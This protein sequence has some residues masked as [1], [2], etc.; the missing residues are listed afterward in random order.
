MVLKK[1]KVLEVGRIVLDQHQLERLQCIVSVEKNDLANLLLECAQLTEGIQQLCLLKKIGCMLRKLGG[2]DVHHSQSSTC[3]EILVRIYW[4]LE[5]R[6]PLKRATASALNGI[7]ENLKEEVVSCLISCLKKEMLIVDKSHIRK[8]IDSIA[9]CM[10]NFSLGEM[11]TQY[12]YLEVLQFLHMTLVDFKLQN[13]NLGGQHILQNKLMHD[14]L[15]ALKATMVLVQKVQEKIHDVLCRNTESSL[16]E[17]MCGLLTCV[18]EILLDGDFLQTV[19]STAG[20]AAL[21]F[22]KTIADC[23][24]LLPKLVHDL[25]FNSNQRA[26]DVPEWLIQSCG[27]LYST[28]PP[29]DVVLFLSQGSLAMLDW[30]GG[31]MRNSG[32]HLLLDILTVLLSLN[33]RLKESSMAMTVSRNLSLWTT[34]ALDAL[35]VDTCSQYLKN[36]LNGNSEA[37][38][39][40]LEYI[41]THWEHPLDGVR[42]QTKTIFKNI[43]KIHQK[44]IDDTCVLTDPFFLNITHNLMSLEW[45]VKGKYVLLGCLVE[46]F[47][48]EHI[49]TVDESIPKQ[50]LGINLEQS[51]ATYA[52]DLLEKMFVS[53]KNQLISSSESGYW[54]KRWHDIWVSPFL[55]KLCEEKPS[56]TTYIIECYLPKLLKCNPDSLTF[57]I[58]ELQSS[59]KASNVGPFNNRGALGALMTCLRAARA[60]GLLST[61]EE[62]AWDE[63]IPISLI[64]QALVHK[65]EQVCLDALGLICETHCSTEALSQQEIALIKYFLPYNMNSQSPAMRQQIVWLMK[66]LFSRLRDSSQVLYKQTQPTKQKNALCE[67]SPKSQQAEIQLQQYKD[68]MVWICDTL[69]QALFPGASFP[70]KFIALNLLGIIAEVFENLE[71]QTYRVMQMT[72]VLQ[73]ANVDALL[74]CL[75]STFE[76]LKLLAYD[77]LKKLPPTVLGLQDSE[78]LQTLLQTALDLSTSTK[79]YD[80]ITASYLLSLL[81]QQEGLMP[82]LSACPLK[83]QTGH[84]ID[85]LGKVCGKQSTDKEVLETNVLEVIK[86]LLNCLSDEI[87]QA[88]RSLV[89]TAASNPLYGRVH[90]IIGALQQLSLKSVSK[91]AEWRETVA[92]LI[93]MAFHLSAVVSPICQSSSPEGLIPMDTDLETARNLQKI[94]NEIKPWDTN[95]YF[96]QAKLLKSEEDQ[97]LGKNAFEDCKPSENLSMAMM[98]QAG[99]FCQ[100][101]AQMVLVC[102]WRSMKEISLLLGFLC[103]HLPLQSIPDLKDGLLMIHQVGEIGEYFKCQLL[104]SRHR[105][106]FELAYVGFGKLTERLTS[107]KNSDLQKLPQRWLEEVLHEVKSSIPTSKLCATRRSAGIPFYIQALV[108]SEPRASNMSL[109]KLT[110]KELISLAIPSSKCQDETASVPQV[111]SLNILRALFRDTKLGENII[112]YVPEGMQ[113]AILGFTSPVWAVRNSST[114]LFSALITRIFGV[115]RGKDEHSK[116][117]RMTGREFFTRFPTLYPFLLKQLETVANTMDSDSGVLKLHPSLF[118]LLLVLGRLYPSP[119]D[120][121][122]S[123][124]SLAPF[125]PFII[126]CGH[127]PVYRSREMAARAL[128]PFVAMDQILPMA[129]SLMESLPA[130]TDPRIRQNHI[131]GILLQ[132]LHLLRSFFDT[133]QRM[134][135][136][137][138]KE[139]HDIIGCTRAKIWLATQQNSCFLTRAT[140]LDILN[141]LCHQ[142]DKSKTIDPEILNFWQTAHNIILGSELF[143]NEQRFSPVP[144]LIQWQRNITKLTLSV[145]GISVSPQAMSLTPDAIHKLTS[146]TA[147]VE[148]SLLL[149][150]LLCSEF[151]EVRLLTLE[152]VLLWLEEMDSNQVKETNGNVLFLLSQVED[153]L[154]KLAMQEKHPECLAKILKILCHLSID[155]LFPWIVNTSVMSEA[156]LLK[157]ILSIAETGKNSIEMQSVTLTLASKLVNY[158]MLKKQEKSLDSISQDLRQWI[159]LLAQSCGA[160][161]QTEIRLT[162]AKVLIEII[163]SLLAN[164]QLY[165]DLLNTLTLWRCIFTLLQDEEHVV[166]DKATDIMQTI[167]PF[168]KALKEDDISFSVINPSRAMDLGLGVLCELLQIWNQTS[169]GIVT[170]IEWMLGEDNMEGDATNDDVESYDMLFD[171]GEFNLWAE[172]I[173]FANLLQK[174]LLN[175]ISESHVVPDDEPGLRRLTTMAANQA[176][177]VAGLLK[178]LP[179]A[180][181]FSRTA[182]YTRLS[183]QKVRLLNV[184]ELLSLFGLGAVI[185]GHF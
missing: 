67:K 104:Q 166:R 59:D 7:P 159:H 85:Y 178:G 20:M 35:H 50:V 55:M 158:L 71:G 18:I 86:Y 22:I 173:I 5:S 163:P 169:L 175:L 146:G 130:A 151:L 108:S 143:T 168:L 49:L 52:T 97:E 53:H 141:I 61:A 164:K 182:D 154:K 23:D 126:R 15:A 167:P 1:K 155:R 129:M 138:P 45:H 122:S 120:G 48:T 95:D 131:H 80:C 144:G 162:A 133:K 145:L 31:K 19:Q 180:P 8:V 174:H 14:L 153:S 118:L 75:S 12:L 29:D 171:K 13:M 152:T 179:P 6:S 176:Q 24:E 21:L 36:S 54:S 78:K 9:A 113:A 125:V 2:D 172:K 124:L 65:H 92:K 93:L 43:L 149:S 68:F 39:K 42:H 41:W 185:T 74:G 135:S 184:A 87:R 47:G 100:V 66:K 84:Q 112:P 46:Y 94:L 139:L 17:T 148:S 3:M 63:L 127:S 157:W 136:S 34:S 77:I 110:M 115:K 183:I 142:L 98:D 116:K 107:C 119:L 88:E 57:M 51:L 106:A 161:Q 73:P 60:Q 105:G 147:E 128:V 137:L 11:C 33:T 91:V 44:T 170:L 165:F 69:L 25:L 28:P 181:E 72:D 38:Q 26:H 10:E 114:L 56:R 16:W 83:Q 70:R 117:N 32:E 37:I 123:A 82:A 89:H 150:H 160:E 79:P 109:L 102:C 64:K 103:Q 140:F 132:A 134:N 90:C 121:T 111:H 4:G 58:K 156:K 177:R 76:E 27:Q 99:Q 96:T 30:K 101:T 81:V 62:S 40:L